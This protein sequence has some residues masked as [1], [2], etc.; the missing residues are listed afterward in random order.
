MYELRKNEITKMNHLFRNSF[1]SYA[2]PLYEHHF[3][4]GSIDRVHTLKFYHWDDASKIGAY[5]D[6]VLRRIRKY[7]L[8]W[9]SLTNKKFDNYK[10]Q[11]KKEEDELVDYF[12]YEMRKPPS[13]EKELNS[14]KI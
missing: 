9:G 8:H 14:M 6:Y 1:F 10:E 13:E 12:L 7:G 4:L 2:L 11:M 3:K 5:Y